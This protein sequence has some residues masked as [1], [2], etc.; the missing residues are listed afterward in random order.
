M[1]PPRC[2]D[3]GPLL[4]RGLAVFPLPPGAKAAP[5]GW[6]HTIITVG[7]SALEAV[8]ASWPTMSNIG[9]A[10]RASGVIGIDLDRHTTG[11]GANV[12]ADG[13]D[14]FAQIC[15]W[16]RRRWP[17]TLEVATPNDGRHLLFRVPPG[18]VVESVSGGTSR[19]GPGIDIR[20]TGYRLGGYLAGPGSVVGGRE[21]TIA[22]DTDIAMLPDWLVALIGKRDR[23]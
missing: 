12:G 5:A 1:T 22:V 14:Q 10:C 11:H 3:P 20:G 23:R 16:H 6:Q 15:R 19:L 17:H 18:V 13:V 8:R 2:P 9:I 7:A 21:Y 4:N